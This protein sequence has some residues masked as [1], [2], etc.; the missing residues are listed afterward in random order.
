MYPLLEARHVQPCELNVVCVHNTITL[1]GSHR[2]CGD[3][4]ITAAKPTES[5]GSVTR[6]IA[7]RAN[8]VF[9]CYEWCYRRA[10]AK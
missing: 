4:V 9:P 10:K 7:A 8:A 2:Q 5:R 1:R 6:V 3:A